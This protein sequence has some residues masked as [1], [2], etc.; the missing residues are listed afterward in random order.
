MNRPVKR[1]DPF[2]AIRLLSAAERAVWPRAPTAPGSAALLLGSINTRWES[3]LGVLC[4]CVADSSCL[5]QLQMM[6]G[7]G[8]AVAGGGLREGAW[9]ARCGYVRRYETSGCMP[10]SSTGVFRA[11]DYCVGLWGTLTVASDDP[12]ELEHRNT[13]GLTAG[14]G[15]SFGR[16]S[17]Q[18]K[19]KKRPSFQLF[20]DV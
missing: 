12:V 9:G 8:G 16:P 10:A 20:C 15:G 2:S 17:R 5:R 3:K 14:F 19:K 1:N 11:G 7:L 18:K 6:N 4:W 13:A